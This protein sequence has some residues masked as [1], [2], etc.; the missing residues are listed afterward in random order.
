MTA[1]RK[2]LSEVELT[3]LLRPPTEAEV[4][5]ALATFAQKARAHYGARLRGLYLFGSRARGDHR[6][7]SDADVVVVLAHG[8][9]AEWVERR[10]LNRLA[11]DAGFN[12]GLDIQPWPV[13]FAEWNASGPVTPLVHSARREAAPWGGA[14][15]KQQR[16]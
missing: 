10:R 9:W 4:A 7:D 16:S 13:S 5:K 12:C 11:Y 1:V 3:E 6:P 2:R 8:D 14:I 15:V